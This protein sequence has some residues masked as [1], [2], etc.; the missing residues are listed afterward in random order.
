L[1]VCRTISA[2]GAVLADKH[3][4]IFGWIHS[5][6]HDPHFTVAGE[7]PIVSDS[8]SMGSGRSA[9]AGSSSS[10]CAGRQRLRL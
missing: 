2:S 6:T 7:C 3:A 1:N 8:P 5:I 4:R 10:D 9:T